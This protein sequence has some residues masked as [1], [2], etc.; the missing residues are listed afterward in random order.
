MVSA[1]DELLDET[2][3]SFL[4]RLFRK[5]RQSVFKSAIASLNLSRFKTRNWVNFVIAIASSYHQSALP[6]LEHMASQWMGCG[7]LFLR[8]DLVIFT[9]SAPT[10]MLLA[11][12]P[13]SCPMGRPLPNLT[14][15]CACEVA[16]Q[17]AE[18]KVWQVSYRAV[19][20]CLAKEFEVIA[21]CGHCRR[22]WELDTSRLAGRVITVGG[23]CCVAIGYSLADGWI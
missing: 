13:S 4:E 18:R 7:E 20:G 12:D 9:R 21:C 1:E 15:V 6:P 16:S 23:K 10:T 19:R 11:S 3:T 14:A 5:C 22:C 8:S 2:G 17:G